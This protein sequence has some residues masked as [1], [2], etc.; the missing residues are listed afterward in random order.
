MVSFSLWI[1][2]PINPLQTVA[3]PGPLWQPGQVPGNVSAPLERT[4]HQGGEMCLLSTLV[5]TLLGGPTFRLRSAEMKALGSP[6]PAASPMLGS[7][8]ATS[9]RL[10]GIIRTNARS[11]ERRRTPQGKGPVRLFGSRAHTPS[12]VWGCMGSP[13]FSQTITKKKTAAVLPFV[14]TSSPQRRSGLCAPAAAATAGTLDGATSS[15][16]VGGDPRRVASPSRARTQEGGKDARD[17][18]RA[19]SAEAAPPG[20]PIPS[21]RAGEPLT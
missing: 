17:P 3:Q 7:S 14:Q 8:P 18:G 19:A 12:K 4:R 10:A 6:G 11:G 20:A 5:F 9:G 16:A 2:C 1:L 15:G 21:P 13:F